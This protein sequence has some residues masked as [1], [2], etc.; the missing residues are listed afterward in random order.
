VDASILLQILN[1]PPERDG[2]CQ[3]DLF[4]D[5]PESPAYVT[6]KVGLDVETQIYPGDVSSAYDKQKSIATLSI[7][8][9]LE[10]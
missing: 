6:A 9:T 2:F 3:T 1:R 8:E 5:R 4:L 10:T 7:F